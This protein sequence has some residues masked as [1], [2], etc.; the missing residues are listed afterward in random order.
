MIFLRIKGHLRNNFYLDIWVILFLLLSFFIE[1][2][3]EV[4]NGNGFVFDPFNQIFKNYLE[5]ITSSSILFTDYV[6][7]AGLGAT[8]FN[9]A[10]ILIFNL[11][12]VKVLKIRVNG[13]VFA[14]I[15]MICGFAF[16]GK[17]IFNTLPIYAGIYLFSLYKKVP[18]KSYIISILFSTGISPIVSY[19]IFGFGLP[20]Y[21]SIPL[22]IIVGVIVGFIIPSIASHTIIFHEGYNL[23]NIGFAL[24]IVSAL[25][26]AI[27]KFAGLKVETV[28]LYDYN[29]TYLF[30]VL[31]IVLS[32]MFIVIAL[33]CDHKVLSKFLSLCKSSGRLLSD[34]VRDYDKEAVL[35]NFGILGLVLA[36]I[37]I[38]FR[39][40]LNGI[41]FGSAL[42][43]LGFAGFGMHIRNVFPIWIGAG[44]TIYISTLINQDTN[45]TVSTIIAFIFASGLAPI[46]GK[47]GIIYGLAAGVIHIILTPLMVTFHGGFDL[48]NNGF[49]AGFEAMILSVLAEKTFKKE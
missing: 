33:V 20:F 42:S 11:I 38:I 9:V 15:V 13:P 45:L 6:F 26:Y 23:F 39:V 14:G 16:F 43:I 37:G 29:S 2:I 36:L 30:Y 32:L 34:Y 21:I 8:F 44:I 7:I 49:S 5:I 22:G 18:Y 40:P 10:T 4:I 41:T 24:G 25:F 1:P 47:Y 17:N 48:Y 27:F 46:C 19:C 3:L 31:L 28:A 12:M 35:F